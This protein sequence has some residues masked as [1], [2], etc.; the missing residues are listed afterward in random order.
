[1]YIVWSWW[2]WWYGGVFG[3][4]ALIESYVLLAIP[5]TAFTEYILEKKLIYRASYLIL[6]AC[7]ISLNLFQS[8]QFSVGVIHYDSM[9]RKAYWYSLFRTKVEDKFYLM[10]DSPD[11][12]A[13]M[14]GDR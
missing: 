7:F 13:A 11:I 1:M 8:W 10:L 2:C 6:I 3:Q 4:R 14:K 9:S 12:E 5:L